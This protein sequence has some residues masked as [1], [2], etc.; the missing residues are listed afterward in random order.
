MSK[1]NPLPPEALAWLTMWDGVRA[2]TIGDPHIAAL[3]VEQ[4]HSVFAMAH[5]DRDVDRLRSRGDITPIWARPESMPIDP[6]QFDVVVCH[7]SFHKFDAPRALPEI[8][9]VLR[10]G[11]FFAASYVVR[12]DSVPWVRRLVALLRH[13]DPMAMRGDYGQDSLE[14]IDDCKYFPEV[15]HRGFRIWKEI[16]LTDLQHLV[17]AQPLSRGLSEPQRERLADE[18]R[19]LFEQS[20]RPGENLRLPFQLL[21]WR[22]WVDHEELTAPVALPDSGIKIDVPPPSQPRWP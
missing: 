17:A 3:L 16:A 5:E 10:Q 21:A 13:Y 19:S 12:D 18:V 2:L 1:T 14:A 22:A 9:R 20:V 11:G 4:G 7:Q 15:E 6:C 8:A